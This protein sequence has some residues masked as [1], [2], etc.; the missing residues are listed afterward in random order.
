MEDAVA[1]IPR[2]LQVPVEMLEDDHHVVNGVNQR[3]CQ[4]RTAHF[5]GVYDGHGGSQ[6]LLFILYD[7]HFFYISLAICVCRYAFMYVFCT[8]T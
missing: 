4:S 6:V 3:L 8:N 2:L 5:F 7:S 1:V